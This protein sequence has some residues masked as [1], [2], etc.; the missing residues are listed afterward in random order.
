[1]KNFVYT[2]IGIIVLISF[3]IAYQTKAQF[4]AIDTD[5][6]GTGTTTK[7]TAGQ[8]LM[9]FPNGTYGPVA[10]SSLG[11]TGGGG[12]SSLW[13]SVGGALRPLSAYWALPIR[14]PN[15]VATSTATS[16][17]AGAVT[18]PDGGSGIPS[19]GFT[20][21]LDTGLYRAGTNSVGLLGG[22]SGVTWDGSSFRPNSTNRSLGSDANPWQNLYVGRLASN[23]WRIS[24][25]SLIAGT[26]LLTKDR[27]SVV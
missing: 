18:I 23:N 2:I 26:L 1:M 17:F 4:L 24:T 19:L 10:T 14:V 12:G 21:D 6:G 20:S 8:V 11:I 13:E 5:Q 15:V 3:S 16:T 25:S 9:G 7:P 27:K 22:G